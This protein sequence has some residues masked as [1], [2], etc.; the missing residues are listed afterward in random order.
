MSK[1]ILYTIVSLRVLIIILKKANRWCIR[2]VE[3][4]PFCLQMLTDV[5]VIIKNRSSIMVKKRK[6]P[7]LLGESCESKP[8]NRILQSLIC[9]QSTELSLQIK[10]P[11]MSQ[12][13]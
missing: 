4:L 1:K 5:M 2:T 9:K 3:A 8:T 12:K 13:I 7:L 6:W 10:A 11:R